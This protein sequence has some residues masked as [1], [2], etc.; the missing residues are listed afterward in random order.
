[1]SNDPGSI[2]DLGSSTDPRARLIHE[3]GL[4]IRAQQNAVDQM[5]EAAAALLG[6]NRTDARAV[7]ILDQRGP[8]TAGELAQAMGLSTG[9]VTTVLDRLDRAGFARRVRDDRDRRKVVAEITEEARRRAWEIYGPV[10]E[11][12]YQE[13]SRLTDRQLT[14]L[15]DLLN[16]GTEFLIEHAARVREM[17]GRQTR[18][19]PSARS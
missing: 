4:A 9:A 2:R 14:A 16:G 10:A 19:A 13:L 5:D 7:D 1:L 3:A 6:I 17:A 15:R 11:R 8:M 12:G 18:Q